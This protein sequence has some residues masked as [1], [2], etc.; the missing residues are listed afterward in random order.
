MERGRV[1]KGR[2][3]GDGK[4]KYGKEKRQRV[5]RGDWNGKRK[6]IILEER[7]YLRWKGEQ[8]KRKSAVVM[9]K[10]N[11]EGKRGRE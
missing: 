11:M 8:E 9:G 6:V 7:K 1:G 5:G 4:G 3:C 10:A 2:N